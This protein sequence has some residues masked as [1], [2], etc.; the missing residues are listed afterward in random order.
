MVA[1]SNVPVPDAAEGAIYILQKAPR[2]KLFQPVVGFRT[3]PKNL[4]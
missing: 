2:M 3:S 1:P 4:W